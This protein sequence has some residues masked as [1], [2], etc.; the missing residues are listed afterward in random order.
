MRRL[1]VLR[2]EPGAS[3]TLQRAAAM[4]IQAVALPLFA[5]EPLD[6]SVPD[7]R[8]FDGLLLTSANAVRQAGAALSRLQ[9]LPVYAV[10]DVTAAAARDS[11]FDVVQTGTGGVNAL[12]APIPTG[13]RLLHLCGQH[14][15]Q[16]VDPRAEIIAVPV[17]RSRAL[18]PPPGLSELAGQAVA[19][20]SPRAAT[21]LAELV[22]EPLRASVRLAAISNAAAEVCGAGWEAVATATAPS[23]TELLALAARLCQNH[24]K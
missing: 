2:P 22:A 7:P 5:M 17:Y 9:A 15:R 12:L 1:F 13:T 8:R 4:G 23:D 10:G 3:A 24:S 11:G 18:P 19:V 21:R 6:W 16:P 20:H 14:R